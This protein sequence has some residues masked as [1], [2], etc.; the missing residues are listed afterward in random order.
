MQQPHEDLETSS[1][2]RT[3]EV[4]DWLDGA[5]RAAVD[6]KHGSPDPVPHEMA[7][8]PL[9]QNTASAPARPA[10]PRRID[11]SAKSNPPVRRS[12]DPMRV[13]MPTHDSS[14]GQSSPLLR[15]G[16]IV[17][18]AAIVAYGIA[19]FSPQPR[20]VAAAVD[21]TQ[22]AAG[23]TPSETQI[24]PHLIVHDQQ[25]FTNDPLPLYVTVDRSLANA[26]LR[27]AGL[28]SG[29][30]LSAGSPVGD[31]GWTVPLDGLKNLFMYAPT[32]F[33]GVMHSAVDLRGPDKKLID[34][35]EV[36]LEWIE[37]KKDP[38]RIGEPD[39]AANPAPPINMAKQVDLAKP[40]DLGKQ[41]DWGKQIDLGKQSSAAKDTV[42]ASAVTKDPVGN[43]VVTKDPIMSPVVVKDPLMSK[44]TAESLM[45]R[46]QDSLKSGDIVTARML[47]GRLADAGV[48]DAA[49]VAGQTYDSAYLAAHHVLGVAGDEAKAHEFYQRAA[50]LGSTD[51]AAHL[52][53][54]IA[55]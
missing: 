36:K 2:E 21:A 17:G 27:V 29:T 41:V 11:R 33:V 22:P 14:N 24:A 30:H 26:S 40:V 16:L 9:D 35:R 55:K 39:I 54:V 1:D 34:R 49:F 48:A 46:G 43:P 7:D 53:G 18:A 50:Q 45:E 42:V 8:P 38:A 19:A 23:A 28:A 47:F 4:H 37:R 6:A 5:I 15:Y 52:A 31:S 32:D 3:L 10:S 20:R 44:E 12:L 25:V 51:A 13:P